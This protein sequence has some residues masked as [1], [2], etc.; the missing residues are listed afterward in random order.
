MS[1]VFVTPEGILPLS[2]LHKRGIFPLSSVTPVKIIRD[3]S[4]PRGG[5]F[6]CLCYTRGDIASV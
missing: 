6:H 4:Y 5:Y 1:T 3:L 2:E